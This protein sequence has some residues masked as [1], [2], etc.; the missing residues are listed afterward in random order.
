MGHIMSEYSLIYVIHTH[1]DKK[2]ILITGTSSGMGLEAVK[3]LSADGH[4]VYGTVRKQDDFA[5]VEKAGG[6]PLIMEMTDYSSLEAGVD[7][8]IKEQGNID[9]LYNNAG[10]GLYGPVEDISIEDAKHQF[11]VNLFGLARLTQLVLPHMRKASSGLIINTSSMGGKIYTPLGAWYHA[12]KHALEGWSD[13]LRLELKEF[14]INV[15]VIE[16]GGIETKFGDPVAASLKK[17]KDTTVYTIVG[18]MLRATEEMTASG[19]FKGSH[20]SVIIALVKKAIAADKPKTRYVA[21]K[22][23]RQLMY[24]R[25]LFGDNVYDRMVMRMVR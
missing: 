9:V 10:Y 2:V 18:N 19:R 24:M 21:G 15:V 1:M 5:I 11:D 20:P 3:E 22:F 12:T 8:I 6:K 14:N 17:I 25:K 7:K 23:A 16:P 4:T 13:C